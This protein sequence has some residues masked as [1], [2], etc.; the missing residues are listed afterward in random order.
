VRCVRCSDVPPALS[1]SLSPTSNRLSEWRARVLAAPR[2]NLCFVAAAAHGLDKELR[3]H[4]SSKHG[5]SCATEPMGRKRQYKD[6]NASRFEVHFLSAHYCLMPVGDT[7]SRAAIVESM[8]FGCIPVF[9][10][11]ALDEYNEIALHPYVLG[12]DGGDRG[13]RRRTSFGAGPWAVLLETRAVMHSHGY[14]G[15]ALQNISVSDRGRMR[16][17]IVE[18][19]PRLQYSAR[20]VPEM[21][22]AVEV[23]LEGVQTAVE[24]ADEVCAAGGTT[25]RWEGAAAGLCHVPPS[26]ADGPGPLNDAAS[27]ADHLWNVFGVTPTRR[28]IN[29]FSG[30]DLA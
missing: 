21:H 30:P 8:V 20:Y 13:S 23:M 14:V 18:A 17:T 6:Y 26:S 2:G 25:R 12:G 10:S 16:A 24:A 27:V 9:F 22:D 5:S 4:L 15:K 1:P 28:Q 7:P 19:L 11:N 3:S 29:R